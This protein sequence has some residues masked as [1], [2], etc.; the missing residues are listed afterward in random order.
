MWRC[1]DK[2]SRRT[3]ALKDSIVALSVGF[4]GRLKSSCTW[5]VYAQWSKAREVNSVPLST[6]IVA[7]KPRVKL[8]RV[9][10]VAT[11]W[12]RKWLP[13]SSAT[14]SRVY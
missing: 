5:F 7:G 4:P 8:T 11:S 13:T 12:P 10:I 2:H 3:L 9:R 1:R 14:H 6:L